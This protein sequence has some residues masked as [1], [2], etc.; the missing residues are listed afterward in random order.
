L[1]CI[2]IVVTKPKCIDIT[3]VNPPC[4]KIEPF[5]NP[6]TGDV[7][8]DDSGSMYVDSIDTSGTE[9]D[10]YYIVEYGNR[11]F[12]FKIDKNLTVHLIN[13]GDLCYRVDMDSLNPSDFVIYDTAD[14]DNNCTPP[15]HVRDISSM[16]EGTYFIP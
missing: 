8:I 10:V 3:V 14:P 6:I 4:I 9:Y 5:I 15:C 7:Y 12:T 16:T 11:H 2:N 13:N 1:S